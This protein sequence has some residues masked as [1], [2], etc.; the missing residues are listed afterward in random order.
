MPI[1]GLAFQ[2]ATKLLQ[3]T[4]KAFDTL[5]Q[6]K[7]F[8]NILIHN[9]WSLFWVIESLLPFKS[10]IVKQRIPHNLVCFLH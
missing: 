2:V 6:I 10:T 3:V 7:F 5:N 1:Q 4:N 8:K 9:V